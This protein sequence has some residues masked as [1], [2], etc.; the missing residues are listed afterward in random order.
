MNDN[1]LEDLHLTETARLALASA[2][3]WVNF[4]FIVGSVAEAICLL[5]AFSNLVNGIAP[6]ENEPEDLGIPYLFHAALLFLAAL[7]MAYPLLRMRRMVR[8]ARPAL[9]DGDPQALETAIKSFR[10]LLIF[11]GL[12]AIVLII[13]LAIL[14]IGSLLA[15]TLMTEL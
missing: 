4:L 12:I 5:L 9:Q 14:L 6:P 8:C 1:M 15:T 13:L 3:R 10:K 7:C 11:F 2:L